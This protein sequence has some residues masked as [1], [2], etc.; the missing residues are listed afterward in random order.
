MKD[1]LGVF[2]SNG[3]DTVELKSTIIRPSWLISLMEAVRL[4]VSSTFSTIGPSSTISTVTSYFSSF[5]SSNFR[6]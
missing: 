2:V 5:V 6:M 3:I 4:L 1:E